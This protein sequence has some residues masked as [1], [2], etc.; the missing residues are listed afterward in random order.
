MSLTTEPE[1]LNSHQRHTLLQIL[2]HPVG[3]NI[4]WRAVLSLL[5]AVGFVEEHHEGRFQVTLGA[6]TEMLER[7]KGKDIDAQQVVN[8]RRMLTHAG[9]EAK[10][11]TGDATGK[12]A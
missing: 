3:H 10:V 11:P 12:E 4:E 7:P 9:Y 1:H 2:Q 5:E 8:L 6:E